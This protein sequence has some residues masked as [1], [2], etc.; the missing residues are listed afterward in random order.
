MP[1]RSRVRWSDGYLNYCTTCGEDFGGIVAFDLHRVGE[2]EHLF[3]AEHPEGRR[4]LSSQ[5]M[6]ACGMWR[7][8][9]GRWSQPRKGMSD[10]VGLS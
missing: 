4:C 3:S 1:T 9:R 6:V 5:E 2:H 7:G 10:V 8:A